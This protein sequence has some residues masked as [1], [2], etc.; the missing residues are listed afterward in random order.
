MLVPNSALGATL[1][2]FNQLLL[3][4]GYLFHQKQHMMRTPEKEV[5]G[6]SRATRLKPTLTLVGTT[7]TPN[8]GPGFLEE[9]HDLPGTLS[10]VLCEWKGKYHFG[11]EHLPMDRHINLRFH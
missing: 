9:G 3:M 8:M 7:L 5:F 4:L 6:L 1:T 2:Q 11:K 10:Q